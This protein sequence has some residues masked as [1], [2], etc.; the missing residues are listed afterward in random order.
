VNSYTR[1]A[2]GKMAWQVRVFDAL[3]EDLVW[4]PD[5]KKQHVNIYNSSFR[6]SNVLISTGTYTHV[7]HIHTQAQAHMY[8]KRKE[9]KRKEKKKEKGREGKGREGKGREGKE[10]KGKERKGKE[11]KGKERKG[12][13]R[14][15]MWWPNPSTQETELD[16]TVS[17][18][19]A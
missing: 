11:R 7:V 15:Q 1:K 16:G 12:K 4:F 5:P 6:G 14:S 18:R 13:E 2:A 8:K 19:P 17:L 3:T 10:R 9:K